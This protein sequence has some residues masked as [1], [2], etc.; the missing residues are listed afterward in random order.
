MSR[1]ASRRMQAVHGGALKGLMNVAVAIVDL[2][3]GW[4]EG[5]RTARQAREMS[6]WGV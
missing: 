4:V 6:G 5:S 2:S 1:L 3:N